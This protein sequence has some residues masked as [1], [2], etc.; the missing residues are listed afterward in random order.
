MNRR[1]VLMGVLGMVLAATAVR[2]DVPKTVTLFGQE[3]DV[4]VHS[5]EGTYKNALKVTQPPIFDADGFL[6]NNRRNNIDFAPGATAEQDR[7]F[8]V[9]TPDPTEGREPSDQF[10]VLTG[11]DANGLFNT[12]SSTLTQFFGGPVAASRGGRPSDVT[13]ISDENTGAKQDKN[14]VLTTFN[15]DDFYRFYDLDTLGGDYKSD[16]V[17]HQP[18]QIVAGIG[19]ITDADAPNSGETAADH[20]DPN[21]PS[22]SQFTHARGGPNGT[23]VAMAQPLDISGA[24]VGLMDPKT[25]KFHNVKTNLN[26][27]T[28]SD[29]LPT[30]E[31]EMPHSLVHIAGNEFWFI[32]TSPDPGGNG[33]ERTR[34]DLVRVELT[35]PTDLNAGANS[36]KANVLGSVDLLATG[37]AAPTVAPDETETNNGIFGL[38][39][40]REVSAG[41]RII[42]MTDWNGNILTLRPRG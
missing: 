21:A 3:Y 9:T 5:L 14:I 23:L 6:I 1:Q 24:E 18:S 11:T 40:G 29:L 30:D 39:V 12:Q 2:A 36:I 22:R 4:T 37:L 10:Y 33:A 31:T 15:G 26:E 13:W 27:V 35:F 7:L 19:A 42:Y 17:D 38:A 32:Y 16:E 8:V 20:A 34:N 28:G 41:K 25:G